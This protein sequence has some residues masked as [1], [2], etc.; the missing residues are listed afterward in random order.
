MGK[1][2]N[3]EIEAALCRNYSVLVVT[4]PLDR[5]Q[6]S[7]ADYSTISIRLGTPV[8]KVDSPVIPGTRVLNTLPDGASVLID[9]VYHGSTLLTIGSIEPGTYG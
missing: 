9:D 4:R 7:N 5:S 8:L 6:I 1:Y 2:L 3:N